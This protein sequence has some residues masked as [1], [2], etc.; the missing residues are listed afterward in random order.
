MVKHS[1]P[2]IHD[3]FINS[4]EVSPC[5]FSCP[6]F[7][8][9][10]FGIYTSA[11][12]CLCCV[13]FLLFNPFLVPGGI[14][15]HWCMVKWHRY[16]LFAHHN[17]FA[18]ECDVSCLENVPRKSPRGP[19][20]EYEFSICKLVTKVERFTFIRSLHDLRIQLCELRQ[21]NLSGSSVPWASS[22]LLMSAC[23]SFTFSL[24]LSLHPV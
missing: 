15:V 9:L 24:S 10:S 4:L 16:L 21:P 2:L 17:T 1:N 13:L 20:K 11:T 12:L 6:G 3:I 14:M 19:P 8:C 7:M 18:V 5:S 22:R 23:L